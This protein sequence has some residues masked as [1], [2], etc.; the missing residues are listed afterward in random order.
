MDS[1][2]GLGGTKGLLPTTERVWAARKKEKVDD[3][4]SGQGKRDSHEREEKRGEE[5]QKASVLQGP[6]QEQTLSGM[7]EEDVGYGV[8]KPRKRTSGKVDLVI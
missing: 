4:H 3:R 8:A 1:Y 2:A 5:G 7:N 6:F